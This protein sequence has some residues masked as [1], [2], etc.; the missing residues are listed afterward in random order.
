MARALADA[1]KVN[2]MVRGWE[3]RTP[4]ITALLQQKTRAIGAHPLTIP[5]LSS[6]Y[7]SDPLHV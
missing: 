5:Y 4:L 1:N 3:G 6:P 7:S 2:N